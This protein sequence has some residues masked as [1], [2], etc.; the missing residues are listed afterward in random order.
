MYR[1]HHLA[2]F[3]PC[4]SLFPSFQFWFLWK[5]LAGYLFR[6]VL[7]SCLSQS[8]RLAILP[9]FPSGQNPVLPVWKL[10]VAIPFSYFSILVPRGASHL[11]HER[12]LVISSFFARSFGAYG[13]YSI[14]YLLF[15]LF[16]SNCFKLP[17]TVLTCL[18]GSAPLSSCW[19]SW[20]FFL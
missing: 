20:L 5:S 6:D 2:S 11:R 19:G 16:L 13:F 9:F 17:L 1:A 12:L 4:F 3:I 15:C 8:H 10:F 18:E 7:R 14:S